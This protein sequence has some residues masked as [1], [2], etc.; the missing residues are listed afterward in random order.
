MAH[1]EKYTMADVT[2]IFIHYDRSPGHSLS[3]KDI[4]KSR[5]HLNYNLA[6]ADQ[7]MPQ[8]KFLRIRLKQIK[9]NGRKNQ[10]VMVD[11]VIT[12]P[13]DVNEID[14]K[15][16]FQ[17]VYRFLSKRQMACFELTLLETVI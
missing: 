14:S 5:T 3:N 10:N 15:R 13:T 7:P 16:F 8:K 4:D 17:E 2:G 12:Q 11:W 9:T 6:A 1:V